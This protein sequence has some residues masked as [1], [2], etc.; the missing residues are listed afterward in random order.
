MEKDLSGLELIKKLSLERPQT[1]LYFA[2]KD[3]KDVA[4]I[5]A[6]GNYVAKFENEIDAQYT[7][8][9]VN[10]FYSVCEALEQ[11]HKLIKWLQIKYITMEKRDD[12]AA[13]RTTIALSSIE[14]ALN[15]IK[16]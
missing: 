6:S 15:N 9:A 2:V 16:L 10:N 14:K 8:L 1:G 4:H 7:A 12:H 11:S 13:T 5:M 3:E